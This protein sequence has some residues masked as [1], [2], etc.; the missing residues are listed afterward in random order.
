M[1]ITSHQN[2]KEWLEECREQS[3][4]DA[5]TTAINRFFNWYTNYLK[6][7][8]QPIETPVE[9]LLSLTGKD[10]RH[11]ALLFQNQYNGKANGNIS[12][13]TA[14]S[15]FLTHMDV[16]IKWKGKRLQVEPDTTSHEFNRDDLRRMF[17]EANDKEKAILALGTSLG[18][19]IGAMLTIDRD[20]AKQ[21]IQKA[22]EEQKE[23]AYFLSLRHK[24]KV[25]RLGVFNPLC[26][27][28]LNNYL[29]QTEGMELRK[30]KPNRVKAY[31]PVSNIFDMTETGI[32]Q[33]LRR[34]AKKARIV[35]TG[36]IH[37]HI[38]RSFVMDELSNAG[39]NEFQIKFTVGKKIPV[40]DIT[41][42]K[43]LRKQVEERYPAAFE[44]YLNI[45]C[46]ISDKTV[47][48]IV[49]EKEQNNKEIAD[50]K[51]QLAGLSETVQ[52][53]LNSEER[54]NHLQEIKKTNIQNIST[55]E[56]Q[57]PLVAKA[58]KIT[59]NRINSNVEIL[60]KDIQVAK[61]KLKKKPNFS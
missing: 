58:G 33:L 43:K 37:Y 10:R 3:T 36:R 47:T 4:K 60:T 32:N 44:L 59:V 28:W 26:I 27:Q 13:T 8:K 57:Y 31:M 53:L 45:G 11:I 16:P 54:L 5:Y 23:Y 17:T 49:K 52:Q 18:W 6:T 12:I 14:L 24:T 29:I 46:P 15:S 25:K 2:I 42:L 38:I 56:K 55:I 1:D 61:Q 50:M 41:Y 34:L 40:S 48:E 22:V 21:L 51:Q 39:F 30:R 35:T 20:F 9:T 19:E 7:N